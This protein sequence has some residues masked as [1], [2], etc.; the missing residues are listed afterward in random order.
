M[1]VSLPSHVPSW[2]VPWT[3][4]GALAS[5]TTSGAGFPRYLED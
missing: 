3:T 4:S 1:S 5:W 2:S